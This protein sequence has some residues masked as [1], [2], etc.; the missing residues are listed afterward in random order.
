M[1]DVLVTARAAVVSDLLVIAPFVVGSDRRSPNVN[2]KGSIPTKRY[3][4]RASTGGYRC[5][6][7]VC[8]N[9]HILKVSK[10]AFTSVPSVDPV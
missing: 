6:A 2:S 3:T 5:A 7:G 10:G 4:E 9:P 8:E 1:N